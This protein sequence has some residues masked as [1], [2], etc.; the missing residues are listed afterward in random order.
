MFVKKRQKLIYESN[1]IEK[2]NKII[3]QYLHSSYDM[4]LYQKIISLGGYIEEH[5]SIYA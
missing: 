3:N 1:I 4:I 5:N 2:T